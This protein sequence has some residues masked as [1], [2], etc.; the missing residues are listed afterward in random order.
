MGVKQGGGD[1]ESCVVVEEEEDVESSPHLHTLPKDEEAAD[2]DKLCVI[3]MTEARSHVL[4]PCGH[5]CLC[6][7]CAAVG[8][9]PL[10]REVVLTTVKVF[11]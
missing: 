4:V 2:E 9:C 11:M 3:C 10:C 7:G 5:M 6:A 1:R 8:R